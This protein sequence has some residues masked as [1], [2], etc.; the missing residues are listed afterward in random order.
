MIPVK[1]SIYYSPV[2][3]SPPQAAY[4]A[5]SIQLSSFFRISSRFMF[6]LLSNVHRIAVITVPA[7]EPFA[8]CAAV[9]C[10]PRIAVFSIAAGFTRALIQFIHRYL[11]FWFNLKNT[12]F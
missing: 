6:L 9:S 2:S 1:I 7:S 10:I 3:I 5:I 11:L 4:P 12:L 8:E